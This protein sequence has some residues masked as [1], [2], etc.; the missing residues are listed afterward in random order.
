MKSCE[1]SINTLPA[2]KESRL[3]NG[4]SQRITICW[5]HSNGTC[6]ELSS[7]ISY[8]H[9]STTHGTKSEILRPREFAVP[10]A[11]LRELQLNK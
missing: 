4:G 8:L 7:I 5:C 9:T 1:L 10:A 11:F 2:F 3:P 6:A